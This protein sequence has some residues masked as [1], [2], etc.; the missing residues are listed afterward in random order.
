MVFKQLEGFQH[1]DGDGM[2]PAMGCQK[3]GQKGT[4]LGRTLIPIQ[5]EICLNLADLPRI[6]QSNPPSIFKYGTVV[7]VSSFN[8]ELASGSF[9]RCTSG[10][11]AHKGE[12]SGRDVAMVT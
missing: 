3:T 12:E 6:L 7:V 8:F 10:W 1:F 2:V 4:Q 9:V 11:Y 5:R